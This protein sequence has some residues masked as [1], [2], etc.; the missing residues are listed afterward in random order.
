MAPNRD[1][2]VTCTAYKHRCPASAST[3]STSAPR[4]RRQ[5]RLELRPSRLG[6]VDQ[7]LRAPHPGIL[8]DRSIHTESPSGPGLTLQV[9][10]STFPAVSMISRIL[11][12]RRAA[13]PLPYADGSSQLLAA[14][15]VRWAASTGP[16]RNPIADSTG[17][18][19]GVNQPDDTWFLAGTFG[20]ETVRSC[21]IPAGRPIFLPA[22]NMWH[23]HA[24]G[25]PPHL[26]KAFG[27]L[28]VDGIPTE[29]D[30][31]ATPTPFEVAGAGLNPVTTTRK[32]IPMTVWGLWR[33]LDPL[34]P[35]KHLLHV[36]GGDGYGFTVHVTYHL[37]V[38]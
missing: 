30:I 22:F 16:V 17:Q 35:G 11:G 37:N 36:H 21:T 31:I 38:A 7:V 3:A 34:T 19:A 27:E 23:R 32:P 15:W 4:T 12:A 1:R 20:G 29:L 28:T 6:Q 33:R 18:Y 24:T 5:L 9:D 13:V 14:R 25:A 10:Q 2:D 8:P 26:P